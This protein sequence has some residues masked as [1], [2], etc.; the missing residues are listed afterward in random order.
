MLK[1]NTFNANIGANYPNPECAILM[2]N[3]ASTGT[4]PWGFY[5]GVVKHTATDQSSGLRYDIGNC[6]IDNTIYT[7]TGQTTFNPTISL[8]NNGFVG[9]GTTTPE[10]K[11]HF[12]GYTL[13]NNRTTFNSILNVSGFASLN[14]ATILSSLN[15]SGFTTLSNNTTINGILN[16]SS[17]SIF[18][19][20]ATMLSSLNVSGKTTIGVDP[21]SQYSVFKV[22]NNI[23]VEKN[24]INIYGTN[25]GDYSYISA[26]A[27]IS[28]CNITLE[29]GAFDFGGVK[30]GAIAL[31]SFNTQVNG[32]LNVSGKVTFGQ[33]P[34]PISD[35]VFSIYNNLYVIKK[36]A[37]LENKYIGDV[38]HLNAGTTA[39]SYITIADN[40]NITIQSTNG[41]TRIYGKKLDLF[42]TDS[43]SFNGKVT[44]YIT[45]RSPVF[46]T[47]TGSVN[48]NSKTYSSYNIDLNLYTKFMTLDGRKI[49]QF[50]VR[51]WHADG[52]F[53]NTDDRINGCNIYMSDFNGLSIK[54]FSNPYINYELNQLNGVTPT[55]Y[56]NTFDI[57]SYLAPITVFGNTVKVYCIFEDLL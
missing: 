11:Y 36:A 20:V 21:P 17:N 56:R 43:I 15:V 6:S 1:H 40:S 12:S 50:R 31:N 23:G 48:I 55:F 51:S 38:I 29:E 54:S 33:E 10:K 37:T 52:D 39:N 24:R 26:G 4:L 16:V 57:L 49:R 32:T 13:F 28:G 19:S 30:A 3:E 35:S 9:F 47:T 53:E 44:G 34:T 5:S 27:G 41:S 42:G 46:F 45:T 22:H 8:F 14:N 2:T 7:M 25:T 18:N